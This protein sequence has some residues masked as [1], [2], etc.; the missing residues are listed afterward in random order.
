MAYTCILV[1]VDVSGLPTLS[2]WQWPDQFQRAAPGG[3][4]T[5][6]TH[7]AHTTPGLAGRFDRFTRSHHRL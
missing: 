1:T 6:S 5:C 4:S 2:Q 7:P 3:F